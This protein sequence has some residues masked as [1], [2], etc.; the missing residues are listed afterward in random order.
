MNA[1][2]AHIYLSTG[3]VPK[4]PVP[5]AKVTIDGLVGDWQRNRKYHGGP[6]RAVCLWSAELIEMLQAEGHPIGPGTTGENLTITGLDWATLRAGSRLQIGPVQL[7]VTDYAAPCR[8]I[9]HC[10]KARRYGRI[11]QSSHPGTSRL[12]ARVLQGGELRINDLVVMQAA[13]PQEL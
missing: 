8:T 11:S 5:Q 6:D 7:E 2:L 13:E 9:A 12:Y 1:S 10:F 3:G 4:L